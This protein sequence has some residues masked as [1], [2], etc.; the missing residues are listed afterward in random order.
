MNRS[1]GLRHGH[2]SAPIVHRAVPEAGAPVRPRFTALIRGQI[3]AVPAAHEPPS[4]RRKAAHSYRHSSQSLLMLHGRK[5]REKTDVL[6]L[7]LGLKLK[8]ADLEYV[9]TNPR[10]G[11]HVMSLMLHRRHGPRPLRKNRH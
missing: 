5:A 10:K 8:Y 6:S 7:A 4:S 9:A 2:F 11:L 1:A 3:L